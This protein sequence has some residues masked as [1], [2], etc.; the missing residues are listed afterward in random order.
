MMLDFVGMR[1]LP[2]GQIILDVDF[3]D[4]GRDGDVVALKRNEASAP[5]ALAHVVDNLGHPHFICEHN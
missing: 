5:N 4:G 3:P 2:G 1:D